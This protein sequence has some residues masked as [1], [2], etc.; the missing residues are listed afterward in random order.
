MSVD[1]VA[2]EWRSLR[3]LVGSTPTAMNLVSDRP[4]SRPLVGSR[5]HLSYG[6]SKDCARFRNAICYQRAG[7]CRDVNNHPERRDGLDTRHLP[8]SVR[9]DCSRPVRDGVSDRSPVVVDVALL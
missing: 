6:T 7:D 1:V 5:V 8:R 9:A 3:G 2:C 4:L